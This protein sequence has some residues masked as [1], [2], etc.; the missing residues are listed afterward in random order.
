MELLLIFIL[1]AILWPNLA[2]FLVIAA[3][4]LALLASLPGCTDP[5]WTYTADDIAASQARCRAAGGTFYASISTISG[6]HMSCTFLD[7]PTYS[8]E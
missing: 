7:R 2:R 1:L 3:L 5:A 6:T 4:V 8:T